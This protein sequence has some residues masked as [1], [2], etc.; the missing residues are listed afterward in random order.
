MLGLVRSEIYPK[1]VLK[2]F[3]PIFFR[4]IFRVAFLLS[5]HIFDCYGISDACLAGDPCR[6]FSSATLISYLFQSVLSTTFLKNFSKLF[7]ILLL[8][9]FVPSAAYLIL[10][11]RLPIC[12]H[13]FQEF[14]ES[15]CIKK[16]APGFPKSSLPRSQKQPAGPDQRAGRL[17]LSRCI[18]AELLRIP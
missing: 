3:V 10:S 17:L 15:F 12:K 14:E 18:L 5:C 1:I 4:N 13:Y 16:Q 11:P 6:F 8:F 2:R 7:T 9:C